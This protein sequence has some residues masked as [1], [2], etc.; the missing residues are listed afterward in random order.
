[1]SNS[2]K[3]NNK[4]SNFNTTITVTGDK[5]LSIRCVLF[6]S[7]ARG[8]SKAFNLLLSEDVLAAISAVKKLG[9]DVRLNKKSCSIAF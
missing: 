4:I 7:I 5:S 2:T 3:M 1:M 8:R 9:I 6:V